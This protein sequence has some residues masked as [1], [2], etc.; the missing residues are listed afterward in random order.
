MRT[1]G[2]SVCG[3]VLA[4][5]LSSIGLAGGKAGTTGAAFLKIGAG[6][7]AAA[8]GNTFTAVADDADASHWNPAGLPQL[9]R[10]EFSAAH[11][12]WIQG[13]QHDSWA[14]AHPSKIGTFAASVVTLSY[15]GI[16]KRIT[17]TDEP[18]GTFGSL[19]AAYSLSYGRRVRPHLSL[20]LGMTYVRQSL[21]GQSAGASTVNVGALWK[22]PIS[23]LT[24]GA[25]VR[26]IG[27]SIDFVEEGDPLPMTVAFGAA[28]RFL[29][30]RLLITA[31]G[32]SV[33]HESPSFG[34]GIE[35]SPPLYK[36]AVGHLRAGYRSDSPEVSDATGFSLG[37][38]FSFPRWGFDATWAPQGA[39][40]DA[41]RYSFRYTF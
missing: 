5:L 23:F 22:T 4:A 8:M 30:E 34:A 25:G 24:L 10:P 16:E 38:G 7:R 35:V 21:D 9:T 36:E 31:E 27:G 1:L 39:L 26:N 3:V 13:G 19:D 33:R 15:E 2:R 11:T 20:G 40:G 17:D 12:Q 32:R 41:F 37:L 6:A 18:E 29:K 28:G 14:Y